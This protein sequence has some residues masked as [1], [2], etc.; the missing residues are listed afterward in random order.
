MKKN[1]VLRL[2]LAA[3]FTAAGVLL[4]MI[5]HF[6]NLGWTFLPMHIP[7]LLCGLIC[8]LPW[9]ALCGLLV[10]LLSSM[11]TGMPVLYP[12]GVAMMLEL[13]TYGL[14]TALLARRMHFIPA[15]LLAMVAGRVVSIVA[16]FLLT[17]SA[18]FVLAKTLTS[19]FVMVWPGILIQIIAIPLIMAGLKRAKV[20][21]LA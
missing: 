11:F 9:G 3:L 4:P 2:T 20:V 10:P 6:F 15:L 19:N 16:G 17:G 5:F 7:V 14:V 18:S 8:G 12:T 13:A 21:P 1:Q